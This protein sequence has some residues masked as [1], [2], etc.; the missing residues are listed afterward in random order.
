MCPMIPASDLIILV[1][2]GALLVAHAVAQLHRL[3]GGDL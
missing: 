1:A 3:T 2:R